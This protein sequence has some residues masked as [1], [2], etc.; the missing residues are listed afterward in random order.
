MLWVDFRCSTLTQQQIS[1]VKNNKKGY[2]LPRCMDDT[3]AKSLWLL[4]YLP[5]H[6]ICENTGFHW[7]VS[8]S[9][10]TK[11]KI[12]PLCKRIRVTENSYYRMFYVVYIHLATDQFSGHVHK[13]KCDFLMVEW[14]RTNR[15]CSVFPNILNF[16]HISFFTHTLK[17]KLKIRQGFLI[18]TETH[19]EF[20]MS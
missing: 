17:W 8:P 18:I 4:T 10:R 1:Q 16:L 20:S 15:I 5:L 14:W 13:R 11:S 3:N 19:T 9:I 7:T 6:K 2:W 12:L